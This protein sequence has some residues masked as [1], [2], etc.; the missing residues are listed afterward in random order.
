MMH[1]VLDPDY[2][3]KIRTYL[4]KVT[5]PGVGAADEEFYAFHG[6]KT[7]SGVHLP[8]DVKALGCWCKLQQPV[9]SDPLQCRRFHCQTLTESNC[10][11]MNKICYTDLIF[12]IRKL[13]V[14]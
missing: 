5:V 10:S 3:G 6:V 9:M 8:T 4:D 13:V 2:Y 7:Y 1:M 14:N 12:K 11:T